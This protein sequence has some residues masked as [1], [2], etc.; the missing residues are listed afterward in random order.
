MKLAHSILVLKREPSRLN[1]ILNNLTEAGYALVTTG[2]AD[3]AIEHAA[4]K[5]FPLVLVETEFLASVIGL[6]GVFR[7]ADALSSI[8]VVTQKVDLNSVVHGIRLRIADVFSI[9]DDD[10]V[11]VGRIRSLLPAAPI[12]VTQLNKQIGQLSEEKQALEERLRALAGEFE[13]WQKTVSGAI[14][15]ATAHISGPGSTTAPTAVN[16]TEVLEFMLGATP[17]AVAPATPVMAE[18]AAGGLRLKPLIDFI[19]KQAGGGTAGQLAVYHVF[20][21]VP[22]NLLHTA[23]IRSLQLVDET[24]EIHSPHLTRVIL[25][26]VRETLGVEYVPSMASTA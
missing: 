6:L 9:T 8:V 13:L 7:R 22:L 25:N 24:V 23:K 1:H 17:G 21:K 2:V 3:E 18:A 4:R 16:Q 26:A 11:I 14:T 15:S 5:S 10:S 12:V 20:L 19:V